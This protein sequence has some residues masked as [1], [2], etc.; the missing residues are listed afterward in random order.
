MR[1]TNS[2]RFLFHPSAVTAKANAKKPSHF[3]HETLLRF[4]AI[5]GDGVCS[6]KRPCQSGAFAMCSAVVLFV[7]IRRMPAIKIVVTAAGRLHLHSDDGRA[8]DIAKCVWINW[9]RPCSSLSLEW[10]QLGLSFPHCTYHGFQQQHSRSP[11]PHNHNTPPANIFFA[12][13]DSL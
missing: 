2:R 3:H 13:R 6:G 10:S 8:L 12:H 9:V 11:F 5:D 1:H 4:M 7:W